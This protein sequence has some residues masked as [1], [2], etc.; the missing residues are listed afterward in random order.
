MT[1]DALREQKGAAAYAPPALPKV[2]RIHLADL[3]DALAA[4]WDDFIAKPS[5]V[6]FL[7]ILYPIIGLFLARL[8]FG[9]DVLPLLFPLAAGFALLGPFAAT[10]F[11][12]ISRRR[13]RGLEP[14]WWSV[15]GLL[16]SQSR[17]SILALG[18]LLMVI[19]FAWI[20]A[21]Q[22]IYEALFGPEPV[23]SLSAFVHQVF[24]TPQGRTLITVGIGVGILF[25]L[26]AF[27]IS[28]VS[29]PLMVDKDVSAP[30]AIITSVRAVLANPFV[31]AAWAAIITAAL[32]VGS[33]PAFL[34]LAVV[35]P[36]LG[37]A[38]WHVYRR[39]V[40]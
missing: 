1:D 27:S 40:A 29:F 9:Y 17:G 33:L 4:G 22:L 23:A 7:G 13:E 14:S 26:L 5:H 20:G 30:A 35:L 2:R 34:G 18:A 38:S 8:T 37:H 16:R 11:Y 6:L 21:A 25:A 28:V 31:M 24:E 36:V 32:I 12:E 19:F 15:F 39:V 10:G 3:R